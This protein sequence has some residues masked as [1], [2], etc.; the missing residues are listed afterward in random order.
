VSNSEKRAI[1]SARGPVARLAEAAAKKCGADDRT[2]KATGHVAK[3]VV[4]GIR[5]VLLPGIIIN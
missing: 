5:R 2:A 1:E 4:K 3:S